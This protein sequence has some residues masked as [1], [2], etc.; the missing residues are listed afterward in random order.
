MTQ[1]SAILLGS[2]PGAV[3]ALSILL[4]RG[5]R[6]PAV[7]TSP[8]SCYPWIAGP[9]LRDAALHRNIPA[10]SNQSQLAQI[11][12]PDFLISYMFRYRVKPETLALPRRAAV[13]FHPAPL[14]EFGGWAFYNVAILENAREYGCTCHHMTAAFDAGPLLKVRRFPIDAEFETAFTLEQKT[15]VEMIRLFTDFCELAE[16]SD[17]LPSTPQNPKKIRYLSRHEFER[18]KQIPPHAG[19]ATIDRYTRAFWYPP[20]ECAYL[21]A[22]GRKCEIVPALAK[23]ELAAL[24]HAHD[25]ENLQKAA[26]EYRPSLLEGHLVHD[27]R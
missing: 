11:P 14:P 16:S 3:V 19:A 15:Q 10:L 27:H 12:A 24:L 13:N 20:Y 4:D 18:L 7:V 26:A 22:G 5:W 8:K 1:P 2:K 23:G 17:T 25:L 21:F 6:V 9:T